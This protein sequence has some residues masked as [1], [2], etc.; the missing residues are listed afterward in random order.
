MISGFYRPNGLVGDM[1]GGSLEVIEV[2]D[3]RVGERHVSLPL[4]ALPVQALLAAA[5]RDA[6]APDRRAADRAACRRR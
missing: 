4:G 1:G 2:L 3:D 6:P 5:G